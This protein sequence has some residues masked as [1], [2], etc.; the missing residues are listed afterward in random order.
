MLED[1][2]VVDAK[3]EQVW[4]WL[5]G[6]ADHYCDWHPNHVSAEWIRGAPNQIGSRL[7]AVEYIDGHREALVF[8][9]TAVD[10]PRRMEYRI[11]GPHSILLTGGAFE[12]SP[13]G[14]RTVFRA[15]IRS[16]FGRLTRAV[17]GRRLDAL[18]SHM[19]EESESVKRLLEVEGD[20]QPGILSEG[21]T[22]APVSRSGGPVGSATE[23]GR[24]AADGF[25][26]ERRAPSEPIDDSR[27]HR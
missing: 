14:R 9:I 20:G 21:S 17:F 25:A 1:A 10:A 24:D 6:L 2:V 26:D 19:R 5:T 12:I 22:F 18:R 27:I 16:R 13:L 8:E 23:S 4:S 3:P 7:E 15:T 11:L